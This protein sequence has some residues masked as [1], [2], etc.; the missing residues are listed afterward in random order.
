MLPMIAAAVGALAVLIATFLVGRW[1]GRQPEFRTLDGFWLR[2]KIKALQERNHLLE[3]AADPG[4]IQQ[5][6]RDLEAAREAFRASDRNLVRHGLQLANARSEIGRLLIEQKTLVEALE[7]ETAF[8]Q[9]VEAE[10]DEL[11]EKA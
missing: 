7:K 10:R 5:L 3:D 9:S 4:L 6:K 2:D 1:R 8:C 11:K